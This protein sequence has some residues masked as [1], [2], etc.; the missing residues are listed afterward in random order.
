MTQVQTDK[1]EQHFRQQLSAMLDGETAPDEA[2]FMLRRLEHDGE[3]AACWER[4][5][6]C[7]DILRGRH[8]ALL[9]AGFSQRVAQ[10]IAEQA[11]P[12]AAAAQAS[13]GSGRPRWGRWGGGAALAASVA[14][15]ALF[16][17]RQPVSDVSDPVQATIPA[18]GSQLAGTTLSPQPAAPLRTQTPSMPAPQAPD[19][20][21]MA[22]AAI[23]AADVPRRA[24]ERRARPQRAATG[25]DARTAT[26]RLVAASTA[27]PAAAAPAPVLDPA[28]IP[29]S[30]F[31]AAAPQG[32]AAASLAGGPFAAQPMAPSRPWPRT[33][34]GGYAGQGALNASY[35][36]GGGNPFL[37]RFD[38][39][40]DLQRTP[41]PAERHDALSGPR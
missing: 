26:E 5:Q 38:P 19:T 2:R 25:A 24:L 23:A 1:Y 16:V 28:S 27:A 17:A 7:G 9:P 4:W 29:A 36:S 15:A 37:P 32:E 20:A 11:M 35:G 22:A 3:L 14:V 40:A 10:A 33:I 34:L 12:E 13:G 8:D 30:Q 18:V 41:A 31:A 21:T 6:L 39:A